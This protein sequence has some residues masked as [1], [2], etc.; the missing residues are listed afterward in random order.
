MI[1][2]F[3]EGQIIIHYVAGFISGKLILGVIPKRR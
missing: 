3:Q 2:L 1:R